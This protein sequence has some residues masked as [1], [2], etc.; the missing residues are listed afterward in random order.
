MMNVPDEN[1]MDVINEEMMIIHSMHSILQDSIKFRECH[2]DK[3]VLG[4]YS[5][6]MEIMDKHMKNIINLF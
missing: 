3:N 1:M 5:I 6:V 2:E 4:E